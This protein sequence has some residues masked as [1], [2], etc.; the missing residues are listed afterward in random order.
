[1]SGRYDTTVDPLEDT[2][3]DLALDVRKLSRI[4]PLVLELQDATAGDDLTY[5]APDTQRIM[6]EQYAKDAEARRW[7]QAAG[8]PVGP[9]VT[10]APGNLGAWTVLTEIRFALRQAVAKVITRHQAVC[11]QHT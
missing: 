6:G 7:A 11:L 5:I 4:L 8:Y 2:V 3:A 10:P 9:G 1:M